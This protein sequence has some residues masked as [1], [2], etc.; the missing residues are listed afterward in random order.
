MARHH[1]S[2]CYTSLFTTPVVVTIIS[3]YNELLSSNVVSRSGPGSSLD[4]LLGSSL[5][6]AFDLYSVSL[7]SVCVSSLLFSSLLFSSL[8]FSALLVA[9]LLFSSFL[10]SVSVSLPSVFSLLSVFSA[11][12]SLLLS[13]CVLSLSLM[14]R[15]TVSRPVCLGIKHPSGA[16]DQIFIAVRKMEYV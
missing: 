9:S 3:V 7:F 2:V 4:L 8:R 11:F 5:R 1:R 12:S 6:C 13:V 14:L 10:S 16:Y 15:P